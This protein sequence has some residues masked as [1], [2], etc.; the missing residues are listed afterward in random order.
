MW[1]NADVIAWCEY[2]MVCHNRCCKLLNSCPASMVNFI[3]VA[4]DIK[5]LKFYHC[6]HKK[7]LKRLLSHTCKDSLTFRPSSMTVHQHTLLASWLSFWIAKRLISCSRVA[8]CW[9][10][11]NF[12]INEP[13]KIHHRSRVTRDS[14][15]WDKQVCIH[16]ALWR[17]HYITTSKEYLTNSH[18]LSLYFVH[19]FW[20]S[21]SSAT[22]GKNFM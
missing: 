2:K 11:E 16:D 18:I 5:L 12:F 17:Q 7:R 10:D 6:S 14:T 3:W 21:I 22:S 15:S 8:Y 9:Y 20:I 13:D 19:I 1:C 4:D